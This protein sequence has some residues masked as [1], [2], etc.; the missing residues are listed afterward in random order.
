MIHATSEK[1]LR[2]GWLN[3]VGYYFL[4]GLLL[5]T[6]LALPVAALTIAARHLVPQ[7]VLDAAGELPLW[8]RVPL[9][10]FVGD[11][12]AYWGHRWCHRLALLW[13]FHAIHHSATHIDWLVN[14]R[15]R[16]LELIVTRF[17]GWCH[18]SPSAWPRRPSATTP[19]LLSI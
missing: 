7:A 8:A 19:C 1:I 3:D 2:R 18:C 9:V 11:V 14:N 13:R 4:N 10:I 15:A 5:S 12:G 6:L 16:P 17:C